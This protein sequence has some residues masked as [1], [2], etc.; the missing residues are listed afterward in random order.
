MS[1]KSNKHGATFLPVNY[2]NKKAS[3]INLD[4]REHRT[5]YS[6]KEAKFIEG[7]GPKEK[8]G[9]QI[10]LRDHDV[11]TVLKPEEI[12][13]SP[14]SDKH[15]S[16]PLPVN[17]LSKKVRKINLKDDS[18]TAQ[19]KKF[20]NL[21]QKIIKVPADGAAAGGE[22]V[23]VD[24]E[25]AGPKGPGMPKL[26]NGTVRGEKEWQQWAQDNVDWLDNQTRKANERPPYNS[27]F[28]SFDLAGAS[29]P[30]MPE[31]SGAVRGEKEWQGWAQDHVDW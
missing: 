3:K 16:T 25:L 27:T 13:M 26:V 20:Q 29:G 4:T 30:G 9:E 5:V 14:K 23:K 8:M 2:L 7:Y 17:Y 11:V 1:P 12:D 21:S 22:E 18:F 19:K 31:L 28:V 6:Q 24:F 10:K 15:G